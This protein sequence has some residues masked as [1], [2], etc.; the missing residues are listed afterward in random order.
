[1]A[2]RADS[3]LPPAGRPTTHDLRGVRIVVV[4]DN[5]AARRSLR[6]ALESWGLDVSDCT[7]PLVALEHV[8]GN[9]AAAFVLLEHTPPAQDGVSFARAIRQ[10]KGAGQVSVVLMTSGG[11]LPD[12]AV[13]AGLVQAH[14][15][16]P[17]KHSSLRDLLVNLHGHRSVTVRPPERED[18]GVLPPLRILLAEDNAVNQ[19]LAQLL[20]KKLGQKPDIVGN[21]LAAV[22]AARNSPYDVVLMDCEMPEMDGF[23]ASRELRRTPP[24]WGRPYII[25][26]TANAMEG[27]KERCL[28]AGMDDYVPKPIRAEVLTA[29]LARVPRC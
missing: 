8:R 11:P 19:R 1:L 21:G 4:D 15:R 22:T 3:A 29:A 16:K 2:F 13:A 18:L 28:A 9:P 14:L 23:E 5:E 12:H 17:V 10:L 7:S 27:D 24:D 6:A 20:L 25:A 26:M